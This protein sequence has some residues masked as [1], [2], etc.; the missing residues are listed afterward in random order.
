MRA[1]VCFITGV[2]FIICIR[3]FFDRLSVFPVDFFGIHVVKRLEPPARSVVFPRGIERKIQIAQV[4]ARF[5][6]CFK[7]TCKRRIALEVDLVFLVF[8]HE[9]L[10]HFNK[11]FSAE[12]RFRETD[13]YH[14]QRRRIRAFR[15]DSVAVVHHHDAACDVRP[16]VA[17]SREPR[18][19]PCGYRKT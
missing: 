17:A 8:Q 15:V 11:P 4:F 6:F 16:I 1:F 18:R 2:V 14:A 5:E 9:T 13:I 7:R 19:K 12:S 3:F 10:R